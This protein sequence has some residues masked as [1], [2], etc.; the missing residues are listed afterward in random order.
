VGTTCVV[1]RSRGDDEAEPNEGIPVPLSIRTFLAVLAGSTV[2]AVGCATAASLDA[3]R[4]ESA[5]IA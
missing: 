4:E 5:P 3:A 2:A 1:K